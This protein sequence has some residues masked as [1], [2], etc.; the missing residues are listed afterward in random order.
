MI[1]R[2]RRRIARARGSEGP[3]SPHSMSSGML[4]SSMVA[5]ILS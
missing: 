5:A 1:A 2:S 3:R 4:F